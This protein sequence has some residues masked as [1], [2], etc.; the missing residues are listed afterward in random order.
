MNN[1]Y[2][3]MITLRRISFLKKNKF[4]RYLKNFIRIFLYKLNSLINSSKSCKTKII[5]VVENANWSIKWDGEYISSEIN[6]K[7]N[8]KIISTSEIPNLNYN[9]KIIHFGS[10]YMWIDWYRSLP[11]NK[12]YVVS[13]FHGKEK[14]SP[15]VKKHI[16][17]FIKSQKPLNLQL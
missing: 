5:Y 6:K 3:K 9:N 11:K 1:A 17:N 16:E 15:E 7:F 12:D 13:F 8:S 4:A 10:Q 14:D 2:K